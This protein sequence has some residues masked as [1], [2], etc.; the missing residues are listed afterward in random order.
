MQRTAA[1]FAVAL[2]AAVLF[3]A[4]AGAQGPLSSPIFVTRYWGQ[5]PLIFGRDD[6][7]LELE[8]SGGGLP[9]KRWYL[10]CLW[11]PERRVISDG[12]HTVT[13]YTPAAR[14]GTDGAACGRRVAAE[15]HW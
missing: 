5:K 10:I 6:A 14:A 13:L 7:A 2:C 4:V 12:G 1:W 15:E 8:S 11:R 9:L 3:T